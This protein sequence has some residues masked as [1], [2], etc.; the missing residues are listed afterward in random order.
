MRLP[1]VYESLDY[2]SIKPLK[3]YRKYLKLINESKDYLRAKTDQELK[4]YW[5]KYINKTKKVNPNNFMQTA[6]IFSIAREVTYRITGKFQYDVQVLGG[7]AAI[8][9]NAVQM[10][11]GSGK[12]LTLI[13]PSVVFGLTHKGTYVLTVNDYLSINKGVKL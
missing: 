9:R 4:E 13:L 3:K 1:S 5:Q 12:T 11:T 8:D 10:S 6:F 7:L 2:E